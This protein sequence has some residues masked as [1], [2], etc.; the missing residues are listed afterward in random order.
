MGTILYRFAS[1]SNPNKAHNIVR[2]RDGVEYC[3]CP[4]W[5]FSKGTG[6]EKT[7]KHLRAW[8]AL[9]SRRSAA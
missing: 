7:C 6:S 5:K 8:Q 9:S 2:G 4:S 3:T 1:M